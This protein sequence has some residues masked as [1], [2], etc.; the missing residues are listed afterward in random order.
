ML[1]FFSC[2]SHF[3]PRALFS[4]EGDLS[5]VKCA[6]SRSEKNVNSAAMVTTVGLGFGF[7][8]K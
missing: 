4:P 3:S 2:T 1:N 6:M 5:L 7:L 8:A